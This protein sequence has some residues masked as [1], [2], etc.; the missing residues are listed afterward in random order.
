MSRPDWDGHVR[1]VVGD[2]PGDS[3][4][5]EDIVRE[6][7]QHLEDRYRQSLAEGASDDEARRLALEELDDARTLVDELA[8][9][10]SSRPRAPV[11][12]LREQGGGVMSGIWQDWRHAWR[13]L[14]RDPWFTAVGVIT[15]AL[16]IGANGAIFSIVHAVLLRPLPYS[17]PNQ[18]VMVWESRPREGVNDN[19]VSPAD[20]LDWRV[21]QRVFEG[22]AAHWTAAVN[23]TGRDE[24]ERVEAGNISASLFDVLGVAPA[25]GRTFRLEEEQAGTNRVVLLNHGFWKR[26]FGSDPTVLGRS[27]T[28]D[29][30]PHE[31]VGVLPASFRFPD[32]TVDLWRPIDFT[33]EDM[34]ARF[35]H[36]LTVYAR[37]KTGT[38]IARAQ[39]EMDAISAQLQNEVPLRNQGHGASVVGLRDRLVGNVE[40]SLAILMAA[41]AFILLIACVNIANLL[42]VRGAGRRKEVALR[43][44]LG[45]GRTRIVRQFVLECVTLAGLSAVVAMPLVVWGVRV[46]KASIPADIPRLN[47]AGLNLVVIGFMAGAAALTALLF[48]L[49]P[50][51]QVSTLS[52]TN[53]LNDA[54][55]N[56]GVSRR[57]TRQ[58]LVVV[59]IA[60]A[61]VLLTGAGLM[62][63]TLINLVTVPPGFVSENVLAVPITTAGTSEGPPERQMAL[64]SDLLERVRM[65]PGVQS[66]GYTSHLPMSGDD[67]R[68]GIGIEGRPPDPSDEPTRAHWRVVTPGYFSALRIR[69]V[70]GRFP[71]DAET[72]ER[73][74][75][76]VI[77]QTA[78][79]RY[80]AGTDA[81]GK[82]FRL[83]NQWRE[84]VGV[85]EDV[86][87][88]GPSVPVNPEVYLP[89]FWPRTNLIVRAAQDPAALAAMV[90]EQVR[91][92]SPAL[93]LA[94]VR[95]LDEVR[96][97]SVASPR[98]YLSLLGAF[99]VLAGLL[100]VLGV[101]GL[102]SYSVAQSRR[103]IGIRM[104]I[105]ARGQDVVRLFLR[106]GLALTAGGL[107][108]GVMGAF[109]LTRLMA[110]LLF[111][112][113]PTDTT[114]FAGTALLMGVVALV[115]SYV[116]AR[117]SAAVDPLSALRHD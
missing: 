13:L 95:T 117:R 81:I 56:A 68:A 11:V 14:R 58:G 55:A 51:W 78:A 44:A 85:I 87:H 88:W 49:A 92:V 37:L 33:E 60:L 31:I 98:F 65:Q 63:R 2:L 7:V 86:R 35:S 23:L 18:L 91:S 3:T 57:R 53:A 107:V 104:A 1:R 66:A 27:I 102:T 5:G 115:A 89:S 76:A 90:R 22:I 45:A 17:Q 106:E 77:N 105:G 94:G 16:G 34:R 26:R 20:F 40:A 70:R 99:A 46:L 42:L 80:W 74:P 25:L 21:R 41:V 39:Q 28:L 100:A 43:S 79:R 36:F 10:R 82:R 38:T 15:L 111:G 30:H 32:E 116:P 101:Y 54:G 19:V 110:A 4:H 75:V 83:Q 24:P 59:E 52:L 61:F 12:E 97:R 96:A 113:T 69:L 47:D 67:S 62:T 73:S 72:Q 8:R 9:P 84:I 93:P 48:S 6:L 29:G 112:V 50:A 109:A 64:L 108:L 114:T 71:T 103:D